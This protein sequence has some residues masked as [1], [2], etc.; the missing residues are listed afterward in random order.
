MEYFSAV[1]NDIIAGKWMELEKII[2]NMVTVMVFCIFKGQPL[3]LPVPLT[4][5]RHLGFLLSVPLSH[6]HTCLFCLSL[7]PPSLSL[8]F[9]KCLALRLFSVSMY[10]LP[11]ACYHMAHHHR[12]G[13]RSGT[14][15]RLCFGTLLAESTVCLELPPGTLQYI[16][17]TTV[18]HTHKDKYVGY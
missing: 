3:P 15:S 4:F 14:S 9:N 18:T 17:I 13:H 16:K 12:L 8:S 6:V 1:K 11:A 10:L 7:S 5:P 2:L